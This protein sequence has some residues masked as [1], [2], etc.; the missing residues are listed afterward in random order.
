MIQHIEAS[1]A[2]SDAPGAALTG[3]HLRQQRQALGLSQSELARRLGYSHS[4]ICR[5]ERGGAC[6]PIPVGHIELVLETLLAARQ[7]Q[8]AWRQ[9]V[10]ELTRLLLAGG[11]KAETR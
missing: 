11:G 3:E 10:N 1:L 2:I 5:W 9:Q 6:D 8:E 4:A 7:Q